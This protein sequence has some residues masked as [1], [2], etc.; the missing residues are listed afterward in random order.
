MQELRF[1]EV[2][3]ILTDLRTAD[4]GVCLSPIIWSILS[5]NIVQH[6]QWSLDHK[7]EA[8]CLYLLLIFSPV[9]LQHLR[10]YCLILQST[11]VKME[12]ELVFHNAVIASKLCW[13][14]QRLW[15]LAVHTK[16]ILPIQH[17]IEVVMR[18]G[19]S[20]ECFWQQQQKFTRVVSSSKKNHF[21]RHCIV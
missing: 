15:R 11:W 13:I 6:L 12:L 9:K 1:C 19:E 8:V 17:L 10:Q 20:N 5:S 4:T 21:L 14:D 7:C 2:D 16:L 3:N 18:N